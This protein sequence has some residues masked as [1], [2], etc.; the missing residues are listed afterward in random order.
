MG[1]VARKVLTAFFAGSLLFNAFAQVNILPNNIV[2][3]DNDNANNFTLHYG[4]LDLNGGSTGNLYGWLNANAVRSWNWMTAYGDLNVYGTKNFIHPHP[5]DSSKII[6]YIAIESGEALTF[7]RGTAQTFSG[8]VQINLPEHFSLVTSSNMPLTVLLTPEA[9]PVVLYTKEKSKSKITVGIKKA[10]FDEFGD[11]KFS[12]QVTG[13]RDGFENQKVIMD[14]DEL[15]KKMDSDELN[16]KSENDLT[17][18]PVMKRIAN[19][20]EKAKRE[21]K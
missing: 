9:K 8:V 17:V 10:D 6:R 15:N 19:I 5:T 12:Y 11:V 18:N 3:R 4:D 13:V 1:F 16:K 20:V 14:L 7:A 2:F 21:K